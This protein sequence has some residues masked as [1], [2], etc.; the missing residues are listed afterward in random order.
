MIGSDANSNVTSK[1]NVL[2]LAL[3]QKQE[4]PESKFKKV[5]DINIA[6]EVHGHVSEG[7][8]KASLVARNYIAI[9]DC[10]TC[11]ACTYAKTKAKGVLKTTTRPV[12]QLFIIFALIRYRISL[13]PSFTWDHPS[14]FQVEE[15]LIS[16]FNE[17]LV[18]KWNVEQHL[19]PS[20]INC[21][22]SKGL[23]FE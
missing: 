5:I 16:L 8:L 13:M 19:P 20:H 3:D 7:P 11:E 9:C 4:S 21:G 18:F 12:G 17:D 14:F 22:C 6:H 15:L 10:K 2:L 1:I 23:S